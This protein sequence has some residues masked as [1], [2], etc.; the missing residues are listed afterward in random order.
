MIDRSCSLDGVLVS[1]SFDSP[2]GPMFAAASGAGLTL[3]EFADRRALRTEVQDAER[4]FAC[5]IRAGENEHL[6]RTRGELAEYFAGTR[7]AFSVAL[8]LRG[9]AFQRRV[10]DRLLA[11]PCGETRSYG[12]IAR[13]LGDPNA[14][15]A[16]GLANGKNRVAI[17]VPC[18]RVINADGSLC[19]YGGGLERKRWLLE[20]EGAAAGPLFARAVAGV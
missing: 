20:H 17:I 6:E 16:V 11:I 13:E 12:G 4:Q 18:H 7:R 9:T 1:G 15:R 3:L 5:E 2:L 19:G 14:T 10:W 8:D